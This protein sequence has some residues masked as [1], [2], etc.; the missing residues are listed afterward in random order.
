[1]TCNNTLVQEIHRILEQLLAEHGGDLKAFVKT[2][3]CR[4]EEAARG[5][6]QSGRVTSTQAQG[7]GP[8]FLS[9]VS[10]KPSR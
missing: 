6:T 7:V 8:A 1:M 2:M 10:L 5:G 4:T 9:S 3:Q